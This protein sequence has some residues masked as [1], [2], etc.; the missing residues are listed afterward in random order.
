VKWDDLQHLV[1]IHC[2]SGLKDLTPSPF[3][4]AITFPTLKTLTIHKTSTDILRFP[5]PQL[6]ELSVSDPEVTLTS[7]ITLS[8]LETLELQL[9]A[10]QM[11]LLSHLNTPKLKSFELK[12]LDPGDLSTSPP[13]ASLTS[14]FK[15]IARG[16][17]DDV[18][19]LLRFLSISDVIIDPD[20]FES[21]LRGCPELT[22]VRVVPLLLS[23]AQKLQW[24]KGKRA[25]G[26][27][28][29]PNLEELKIRILPH[30]LVGKEEA[31]I[32]LKQDLERISEERAA[33]PRPFSVKIFRNIV[34]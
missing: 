28:V 31:E 4:D 12:Q 11:S 27:P 5:F 9:H 14:F 15:T 21:I 30:S 10:S 18:Y 19:A 20:I 29:A 13:S 26:S 22:T 3:T 32:C 7:S 1:L 8:E 17:G 25:D 34:K 2:T 16:S 6:Q 24:L 23:S 33:S